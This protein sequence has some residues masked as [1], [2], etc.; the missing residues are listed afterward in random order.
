MIDFSRDPDF[1]QG[2]IYAA[3]YAELPRRKDELLDLVTDP[4]A[5]VTD[6]VALGRTIAE[7]ICE[8]LA[9]APG[10]EVSK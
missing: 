6:R 3:R 1:L 8:F 5:H 4:D 10:M 9:S 7:L 2:V